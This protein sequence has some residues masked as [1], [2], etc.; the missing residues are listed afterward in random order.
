[1]QRGVLVKIRHGVI[2]PY[3]DAVIGLK[4][5]V[6]E[7]VR[8]GAAAGLPAVA[9]CS[10]NGELAT[11]GVVCEIISVDEGNRVGSLSPPTD[12]VQVELAADQ[13]VKIGTVADFTQYPIVEF[14]EFPFDESDRAV[15]QR[16]AGT[17]T[18][19]LEQLRKMKP[20]RVPDTLPTH[21]RA[22][23]MLMIAKGTLGVPPDQK[24][25]LIRA[26]NYKE[27]EAAL[28]R[29]IPDNI[30][31]DFEATARKGY[32]PP[33]V[34][35]E[36][37]KE[38]ERLRRMP[39]GTQEAA[40]L[41][42]Y[43]DFVSS[44]P[45][46]DPP[47]AEI[48][49]A[50]ARQVLDEDHYNL[51]KVK[52][53]VLEH[54][55]VL[56]L[57]PTARAPILCFV[58]PPG[59]GKTS[60]GRSIARALGRN[61]ERIA[62]GGMHDEAELRGHRRTYVGAMPGKII[63]AVQRAGKNPVI[64]FDEVDKIGRDHRGDPAAAL[65]EILDPEQNK[66]FRDN[67][68]DIPFDLSKVLFIATANTTATISPPLLDRMEIIRLNGYSEEEKA[69][70][71]SKFLVPK[72]MKEIGLTVDDVEFTPGGIRALIHG[73]TREAGVRSLERVIASV[74]R[75]V[76]LDKVEK[77]L[78]RVRI[79][80]ANAHRWV[81]EDIRIR[82]RQRE[83]RVGVA[84][85]LAWSETGGSTLDVEA[86]RLPGKREDIITGHLGQVMRESVQ[87][88]R[89]WLLAH[90]E[91]LGLRAEDLRGAVHVHV[92]EGATPKD[93]PS[94]G[95]AIV[96]AL[97]SLFTRL[98]A[99][100]DVAFTGEITLAG[101]VLPVGGLKEKILAARRDGIRHV[102]LP[103][104]NREDVRE[105]NKLGVKFTFVRH[106]REALPH[107]LEVKNGR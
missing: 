6:V 20:G 60:L 80:A 48:D 103:A 30:W 50:R 69:H 72:Q 1:M 31:D 79:S 87:A 57:N 88:A 82:P 13:P 46:E 40:L 56:K 24:L 97:V 3:T 27:L 89:S 23:A 33:H 76:A 105:L 54:L 62:L 68:V 65:L 39:P 75:R 41:R 102:V 93:G 70:I 12:M 47:P 61:F 2:L 99:R 37:D 38:Q 43:I 26:S 17:C 16:I 53:R 71:A 91:E 59:V 81:S 35:A 74:C 9:V 86:V 52:Q 18:A 95:L 5:T 19:M 106:I 64:L 15:G 36:L 85:G 98:P 14:E 104:D 42:D 49:I 63:K 73:Y 78:G 94:A 8:A 55:A 67:Y 58:G 77:G 29:I 32:L 28:K 10:I 34:Q 25:D 96:A 107:A 66:F 22:L 84:V 44:L 90:A 51:E 100:C 83:P 11:H 21:P 92:S 4:R 45:W 7:Q 101:D